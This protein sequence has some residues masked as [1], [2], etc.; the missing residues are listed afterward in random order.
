[1]HIASLQLLRNMVFTTEIG[2]TLQLRFL[3]ITIISR[4]FVSFP[5]L[6]RQITPLEN[7][8]SSNKRQ[9]LA[10]DILSVSVR[11]MWRF[12]SK[13]CWSSRPCWKME[14]ISIYC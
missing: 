4:W 5:Q 1:M 8:R 13:G 9:F 3:D 6:F 2:T 14:W 10:Q 7:G 11:S 12:A